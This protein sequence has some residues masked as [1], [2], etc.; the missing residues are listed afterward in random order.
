MRS[1]YH[2]KTIIYFTK[3]FMLT[4][5]MLLN[6]FIVLW[7]QTI[8]ILPRILLALIVFIFGWFVAKLVYKVIVKIAKKIKLDS[9]VTPF[10]KAME[11]SG[12]RFSLGRAI[13]FLVKWFI[14]ISFLVVALDI[15]QL[16]GLKLILIRLVAYIPQVIISIL[17]LLAGVALAEFTKKLVL[18]SAIFFNVKSAAFFAN[19]SKAIIII[20]SVLIALYN[21]IPSPIINTL[22]TGVVFML[23][24]AGGLA[25]GL[26]GKDAARDAI[27]DVKQLMKKQ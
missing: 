9:A 24:L 8:I 15:L 16:G 13:A 2:K 18:G 6:P 4:T 25:F 26:G 5:D 7:Q 1:T 10:M 20:F 11:R 17:I 23:A 22:F 19:L 14:I 3:K 21:L 27:E 12:Y